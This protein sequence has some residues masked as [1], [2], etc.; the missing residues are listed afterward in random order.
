MQSGNK[1]KVWVRGSELE[2]MVKK[3]W[4]IRELKSY[5]GYV[6]YH[7]SGMLSHE[8]PLNISV[9]SNAMPGKEYNSCRAYRHRLSLVSSHNCVILAPMGWL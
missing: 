6:R 2:I 5:Y 8:C 7:M 3:T 4:R 1:K 9:S